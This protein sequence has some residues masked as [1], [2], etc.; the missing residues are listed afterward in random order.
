[1]C[2]GCI[3][4]LILKASWGWRPVA[5]H[6]VPVNWKYINTSQC[7]PYPNLYVSTS[8]YWFH[9]VFK[10]VESYFIVELCAAHWFA[11]LWGGGG[12]DLITSGH[13][14]RI[15]DTFLI[16]GVNWGI[17]SCRPVIRLSRMHVNVRCEQ[18]RRHTTT[19][20]RNGNKGKAA[21]FVSPIS[22]RRQFKVLHIKY[23]RASWQIVK[24]T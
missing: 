21:L 16:S 19:G 5:G 12:W 20:R 8:T 2:R 23:K 15:G 24:A 10:W 18:G 22:T 13:R 4:D 17:Q 7:F 3:W 9:F 6:H 14:R 11:G 1:M